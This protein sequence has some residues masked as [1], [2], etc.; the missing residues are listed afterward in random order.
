VNPDILSFDAREGLETFFSDPYA[1]EFMQ[2]GGTVAYGMVPTRAGLNAADAATAAGDP[3]EL[4]QRAMITAT[5]GLGLLE[6]SAIAESFSVAHKVGQL[7][8]SLLGA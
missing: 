5:C 1:V 7:V 6:P 8:R 2:R 4:A 3:R